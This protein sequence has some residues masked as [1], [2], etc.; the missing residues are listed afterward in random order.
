M[1][2]AKSRFSILGGGGGQLPV[3]CEHCDIC[4]VTGEGT[5][6]WNTVRHSFTI[7]L[8]L[9]VFLREV[10]IRTYV[11]SNTTNQFVTSE[12]KRSISDT[13]AIH[14]VPFTV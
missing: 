12:G 4:T 1:R 9:A 6:F 5:S 10:S 7:N 2:H 14:L 3:T 11:M 13:I 8:V